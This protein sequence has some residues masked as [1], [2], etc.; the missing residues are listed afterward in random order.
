MDESIVVPLDLSVPHPVACEVAEILACRSEMALRLVTVSFPGDRDKDQLEL[1]RLAKEIDAPRV[2]VEAVASGDVVGALL[3]A[4]G[5]GGILCLETRARG[6]LTAVVFGSVAAEV[7]RKTA[8]PVVLVGPAAKPDPSLGVLEVC[9][10]GPAAATAL[11]P[12]AA[13]W[14]RRFG[15]IP[16]LV[17][18][19]VPGAP[20]RF[21][22]PEAAREV[23]EQTAARLSGD[24]GID[25]DW[26]VIDAPA[27]P[28]A[29][30]GD[31][32]RHQALLVAVA[33][34][35]HPVLQRAL[36]STAVAVAHVT[37]ASVLAVPCPRPAPADVPAAT[38]SPAETT[39]ATLTIASPFPDLRRLR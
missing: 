31:A 5:P 12:V 3:D 9:I 20:R 22:S 25:V 35:P 37:A 18:L 24:V 23:L 21:P 38:G 15:L 4:A 13:A 2:E 34:R 6:P 29:I 17:C 11:E 14:S 32:E 7:L 36:G 33:V 28:A 27:A 39:D 8:R 1:E 16:R 10:D 19:W 26:E 30:V